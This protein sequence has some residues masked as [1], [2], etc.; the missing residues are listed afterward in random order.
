MAIYSNADLVII[1]FRS[2]VLPVVALLKFG[3]LGLAAYIVL[4]FCYYKVLKHA[5]NMESLAMLDEFFLLDSPKNR[6]NIITVVKL[7]KI[8]DYEGF[9]RFV[10]ERAT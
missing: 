7:D 3:I 5:F 8:K 2:Y 6:S 10:I 9:R 1:S 4:L